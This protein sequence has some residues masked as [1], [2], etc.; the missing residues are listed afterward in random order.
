MLL[1]WL[2]N[3][4][5]HLQSLSRVH[6][7]SPS[8]QSLHLLSSTPHFSACASCERW[9]QIVLPLWEA[10]ALWVCGHSFSDLPC[11]HCLSLAPGGRHTLIP[12]RDSVVGAT[13]PLLSSLIQHFSGCVRIVFLFMA[14]TRLWVRS[15]TAGNLFCSSLHSAQYLMHSSCL[16]GICWISFL[17]TKF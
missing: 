8:H 3:S 12:S 2:Q 15:F 10:P 7:P 6:G 4:V 5:A 16:L 14:P 13:N 9:P 11:L 17:K 1:P